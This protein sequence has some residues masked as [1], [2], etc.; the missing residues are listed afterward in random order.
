MQIGRTL[1][2]IGLAIAALGGV[3]ML[4]SKLGMGR[5]PGDIVVRRENFTFYFPLLSSV[6]V[7]LVLTLLFH[8]FKR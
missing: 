4:A 8:L 6:I 1:L 7:S 2:Y 5:L 3:W